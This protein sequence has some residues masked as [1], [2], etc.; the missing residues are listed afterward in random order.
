MNLRLKG[1]ELLE[2][3]SII[4]ISFTHGR[5]MFAD[6]C[7]CTVLLLLLLLLAACCGRCADC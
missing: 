6:M 4:Y 1:L 5:I 3:G 2:L 7:Q